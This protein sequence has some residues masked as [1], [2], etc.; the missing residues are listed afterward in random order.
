MTAVKALIPGLYG[1]VLIL[2]WSLLAANYFSIIAPLLFS[3]DINGKKQDG[4][5]CSHS[6]LKMFPP[7]CA[8]TGEHASGE[9]ISFQF[10]CYR[11]K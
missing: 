11:G 8:I 7:G 6:W 1:L 10:S 2:H 5:R 3:P 4:F 9:I